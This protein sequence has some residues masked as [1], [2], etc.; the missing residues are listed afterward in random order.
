[1]VRWFIIVGLLLAL[2]VGAF[3][4]FNAFRNHMITQFFANKKPP[5]TTRDGLQ[6][7]SPKWCRIC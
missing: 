1:M 2:L 6:R 7:R 4:G 5:P 3:V